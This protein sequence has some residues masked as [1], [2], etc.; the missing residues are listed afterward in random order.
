MVNFW[1]RRN[2]NNTLADETEVEDVFEDSLSE[3]PEETSPLVEEENKSHYEM[4]EEEKEEE[5]KEEEV[6]IS[7]ER[8]NFSKQ[9]TAFSN[10]FLHQE[11]KEDVKVKVYGLF[12]STSPTRQALINVKKTRILSNVSATIPKTNPRRR[13][14]LIPLRV[15]SGSPLSSKVPV[16]L[17][18]TFPMMRAK[19]S[20]TIPTMRA[21]PRR[22]RN[23]LPLSSLNSVLEPSESPAAVMRSS[24]MKFVPFS[25]VHRTR[26]QE[27]VA[28]EKVKEERKK[29]MQ[30]AFLNLK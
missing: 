3:L 4:E 13:S 30:F 8:V 19:L 17:S 27:K 11:E 26:L 28:M 21:S 5:E 25:E 15:P 2:S 20:T 24:P 7:E 1:D 6:A 10:E 14:Q 9:A 22:R 12:N 18:T 16:K 29:V 23:L